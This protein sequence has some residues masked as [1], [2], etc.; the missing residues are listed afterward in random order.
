MNAL[1]S[2]IAHLIRMQ[3]PISV[4]QFMSMALHDPELG[5]Y[6]THDPI[7]AR[8]DFITAPEISQMFGEL[9]GAWIVQAW[10][11][12]GCPTPARLVELGPGRGT[13]VADALRAAKLDPEFLKSIEVVLVEMSASLRQA[14]AEKLKAAP[15]AIHWFDKFDESLT[16]QP[17]FLLANEFFDA[18]P[19]RQFVFGEGGWCER[20]VGVGQSGELVFMLSP[21]PV[22]LHL[23]HERGAPKPGDVYEVCPSGEAIVEQVASVVSDKG[24][25]SL[26][27]DYGYTDVGF[28][29]TLQ[30]VSQHKY[31]SVLDNS[32]ESDLS[33]HVD[34][35]A[36]ARTAER[37]GAKAHGPVDQGALLRALG[38]EQRAER[39][40]A[41]NVDQRDTIAL[42]TKR[43]VSPQA[44]GT[45]FKALA[46]VPRHASTPPGF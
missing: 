37:S 43:L 5:Y 4:A 2:R 31:A 25:V 28:G 11:D 20:M 1:T 13:L 9:L 39:L 35:A 3:G 18:L 16:D 45:L 8:G 29:E 6:A 10:R 30:A 23:P 46:I 40:M 12:Q 27:I 36:L 22:P 24:G 34:F 19:I 17:L 21:A 32:G 7:G 44:M 14:Q 26:I 42:S 38:I 41:A 33:T 15:V